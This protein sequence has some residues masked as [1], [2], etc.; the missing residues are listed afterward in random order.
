MSLPLHGVLQQFGLVYIIEIYMQKVKS[1]FPPTLIST[2]SGTYAVFGSNWISVPA[3][4]TLDEVRRSWIPDRPIKSK[5]E[6]KSI[7]VKVLNSKGTESYDVAFR[8]GIWSCSCPGFGFRR[9]C[10]HT[11]QVKLKHNIK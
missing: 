3:T 6:T 7:S 4:T 2:Q 8:N 10:K 5:S 11:D 1:F 9:K